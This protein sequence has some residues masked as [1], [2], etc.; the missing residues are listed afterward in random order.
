MNSMKFLEWNNL[1]SSFLFNS[2]NAG[3][4]V[5]LYLTK[6]DV[7]NIGREQL[8]NETG[9][10]IWNDFLLK[11]KSGLPGSK[12]YPDIF[13]KALHSYQQWRQNNIK[14][15][16]GIELKYPPYISYLVFAVLP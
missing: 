6:T 11:I 14:S 9:D 4:D 13:D 2:A 8:I 10:A 3:K 12:D 5:Y 16:E 15:I 7:V 1:I